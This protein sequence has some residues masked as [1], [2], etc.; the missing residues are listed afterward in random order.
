MKYEVAQELGYYQHQA[1]NNL[2]SEYENSLDQMKYE[3]ADSLGI[4]MN[5]GYNGD[6]KSRDAGRIGGQMGGHLGGQMVKKMIEYAE[7]KMAEEYGR[8]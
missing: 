7:T 8:Q 6:M 5:H 4:H 2:R 1:D 3:M